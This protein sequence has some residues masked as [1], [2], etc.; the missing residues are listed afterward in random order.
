[1]KC[2]K[3]CGYLIHRREDVQALGRLE[4]VLSS[5]VGGVD[6]QF[7]RDDAIA[8]LGMI[9]SLPVIHCYEEAPEPVEVAIEQVDSP[10]AP[11]VH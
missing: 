7:V 2:Y 10:A 8:A 6:L 4:S 1:M 5:L 3:R 11:A 9:R